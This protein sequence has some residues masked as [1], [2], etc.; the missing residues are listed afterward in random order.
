M[1]KEQ[2]NKFIHRFLQHGLPKGFVKVCYFGFFAPGCCNRLAGL[3]QQ[4]ELVYPY[5]AIQG[6][7]IPE[8]S[9]SSQEPKLY[10]PS[11]GK[12]LLFQRLIQ[13][14]GRCPL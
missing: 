6:D 11:C 5:C 3:P 1:T 7:A 4:L 2:Q 8:S 12:P 14:T 9:D 10:C 13:P